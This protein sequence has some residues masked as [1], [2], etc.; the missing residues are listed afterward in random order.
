MLDKLVQERTDD[1]VIANKDLEAFNLAVSNNLKV[2][3]RHI[4]GYC[5][6]LQKSKELYDSEQSNY[7]DLIYSSAGKLSQMIDDLLSLSIAGRL[8]LSKEKLDLSAISKVVARELQQTEPDREISFNIQPVISARGSERLMRL[9]IEN[10]FSN[11]LKATKNTGNGCVIE[12]GMEKLNGENVY[13]VR[14]NGIG[15]K[16]EQKDQLFKPFALIHRQEEFEGSRIGLVSV[17]RIIQRHGGEITSQ[18]SSDT[19]ALTHH[20]ICYFP[21]SSVRLF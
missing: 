21:E 20:F 18:I 12:F 2:P 14:D 11:A 8:E 13:F 6:I 5:E 16:E 7:L 1:L 19:S 17:Q 10:L 4:N 3:L 15:F 9:V